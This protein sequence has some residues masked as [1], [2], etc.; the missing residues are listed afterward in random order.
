MHMTKKFLAALIA[1]LVLL[2][3]FCTLAEIPD[4]GADAYVY[5]GANVLSQETEGMIVFSNDLLK[6]ACGGEIAVV[7]VRSTNGEA[8][9]D[10]CYDLFNKWG[11]GDKKKQNGLL[12]LLSIED[13]DYYVL[14]GTGLDVELSAG[15]IL[16]INNADLE[17][18]FAKKQYDA[19][20]QKV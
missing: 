17:P 18:D 20:V 14:P 6:E 9:E 10:Y 3:T 12:I 5:D 4:P 8:T 15:K 11:I 13:D 1:L 2:T 19:G 7:T 16:Q